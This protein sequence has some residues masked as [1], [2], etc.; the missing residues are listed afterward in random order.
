MMRIGVLVPTRGIVMQSARRPPVDE[1]WTMAR[2]ADAAGYD[3][4]WVGDS[5]VA[6]PRLE[7]LTTLAYLAGITTR[8]RLGTAVLLPA[9]RHPVVLA[10]QIANVDQIS[11]GRVLLGLGVGWSLPAAEREWAACGADHKRRVRRL[12]EHV[13]LWRRLWQGEPVTYRGDDVELTDH[14]IGPL[15]WRPAGPPVLITAGNRGELLS[16]QFDRLARLG[17]GIITTY[18]HAEECRGIRERAEEALAKRNRQLA[19]FPLCV[20]TTVRLEDDVQT[21]ERVT[22]DFLAAYYGGGVHSRGT[23][24][25]GPPDAVVAALHRYGAAGVTDLCIRFVGDD[26]LAQFERF[27]AQ[28]LPA[29]AR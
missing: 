20:Y 1:C 29:L 16:A 17:D 15:P 14:T 11:R 2:R 28:V 26:Q 18:V 23:M 7:A 6:K 13:E 24:G 8:V 21:A 9:L 22:T 10:H 3:A 25:L 4:V 5:I 12:E 19:D 27:T